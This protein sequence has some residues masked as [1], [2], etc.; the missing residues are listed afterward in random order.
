M[1]DRRELEA[2]QK[3]DRA[4]NEVV[5]FAMVKLT[6]PDLHDA[7]AR[8]MD[9]GSLHMVRRLPEPWHDCEVAVT[10]RPA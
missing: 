2:L 4:L 3:A 6:D 8:L 1:P 10:V 9:R 7:L 5:A